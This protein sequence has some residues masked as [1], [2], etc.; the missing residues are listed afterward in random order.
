MRLKACA[1]FEALWGNARARYTVRTGD[2]KLRTRKKKC[3]KGIT[4]REKSSP[5][6][7]LSSGSRHESCPRLKRPPWRNRPRTAAASCTGPARRRVSCPKGDPVEKV[8]EAEEEEVVEEAEEVEEATAEARGPMASPVALRGSVRARP[9]ARRAPRGARP[10]GPTRR[11]ACGRRAPT[12]RGARAGERA[13]AVPARP[14]TSR[15]P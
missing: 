2:K 14:R 1:V 6:P 7:G 9:A 12:W 5:P 10:P 15:R 8:E 13:R 3:K 4:L 11:G